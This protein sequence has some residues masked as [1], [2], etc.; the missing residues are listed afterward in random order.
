MT[1]ESIR[2]AVAAFRAESA[3]FDSPRAAA[4]WDWDVAHVVGMYRLFFGCEL[5]N[6]PIG[7]WQVGAVTTMENMF[8]GAAAFDQQIGDW[9]VGASSLLP[10][11]IACSAVLRGWGCPCC[12]LCCSPH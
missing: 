3:A 5:F 7:D 1:D 11:S 2:A 12:E 8:R 10:S 9:Q 4:K 6:E